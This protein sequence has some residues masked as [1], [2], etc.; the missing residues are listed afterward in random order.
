MGI[1]KVMRQNPGKSMVLF[2]LARLGCEEL[3]TRVALPLLFHV[4]VPSGFHSV[5]EGFIT[6]GGPVG[7]VILGGLAVI[8]LHGG[9]EKQKLVD[10]DFVVMTDPFFNDSHSL[11]A[12]DSLDDPNALLTTGEKQ[13]LADNFL[14]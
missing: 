8:L 9:V 13:E 12:E 3:V 10:E 5:R 4:H 1:L 2:S 6:L 11:L 14:F 7:D